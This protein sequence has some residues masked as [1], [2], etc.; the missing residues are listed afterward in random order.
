MGTSTGLWRLYF[1]AEAVPF[2]KSLV[3]GQNTRRAMAAGAL[4]NSGE[5]VDYACVSN[6]ANVMKCPAG[7]FTPISREP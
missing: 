7:S 5:R 4:G 6:C 2:D 3:E 1:T